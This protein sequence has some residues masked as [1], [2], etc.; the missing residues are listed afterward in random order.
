VILDDADL[1][2]AQSRLADL[3]CADLRKARIFPVDDLKDEPKRAF[4]EHFRGQRS[5]AGPS[6][7]AGLTRRASLR[8]DASHR[9]SP[10]Q[11]PE[12]PTPARVGG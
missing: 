2:D 5:I 3:R 9:G 8:C 4:Y 12:A 6:G 11:A 1:Y 10:H 7:R